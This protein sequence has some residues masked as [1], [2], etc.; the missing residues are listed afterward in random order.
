M[1]SYFKII[2][3]GIMIEIWIGVISFVT[4]FVSFVYGTRLCWE[5]GRICHFGEKP[6][7][8][9][10]SLR[11]YLPAATAFFLFGFM[12]IFGKYTDTFLSRYVCSL[13][14]AILLSHVL[15]SM[16]IPNLK[17]SQIR[18]SELN[19]F[20]NGKKTCQPNHLSEFVSMVARKTS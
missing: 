8:K 20:N 2:H 19:L 18:Q 7:I 12:L 3:G 4:G 13:T 11:S 14:S 15:V 10:K 5:C 9:K 6:E 17:H 16:F 1:Y